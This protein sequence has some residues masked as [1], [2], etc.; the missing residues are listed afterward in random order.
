MAPSITPHATSLTLDV[1]GLR[2]G[3]SPA[4]VDR[5]IR[6][7][8]PVGWVYVRDR[9]K[10]PTVASTYEWM[11]GYL[12]ADLSEIVLTYY[13]PSLDDGVLVAVRRHS[14]IGKRIAHATVENALVQKYGAP[15]VTG[16]NS[17]VWG[18]P[19][20][21]STSGTG[22]LGLISLRFIEGTPRSD[23]AFQDVLATGLDLATYGSQGPP[24]RYARC[25]P[26]L[27]ALWAPHNGVMTTLADQHFATTRRAPERF[28][29]AAVAF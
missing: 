20:G 19:S 4:E 11:K 9:T 5:I 24:D 22:A 25:G 27:A 2:L 14:M 6:N 29:N 13:E 12:A 28:D 21:C 23:R 3:M 15:A 18:R 26:V 17:W 1:V 16:S 7:Q 8:T 10:R